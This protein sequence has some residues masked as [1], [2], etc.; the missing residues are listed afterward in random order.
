MNRQPSKLDPHAICTAAAILLAVTMAYGPALRAGFIWDDDAY[1]TEN[2]HLESVDGLRRIWF[3]F[4]ATDQY[5][6]LVFTT[7]WIERHLWGLSPL[8]YHLVNILL[9]ATAS[10]LV[11]RAL[12]K[13]N[14]PGAAFAAAIFALHPVH[15]ESVAW[16]TERKNVLSGVFYLSSLLAYLRF[17][18]APDS[19]PHRRRWY[20]IALAFFACALLSKTVTATLPVIIL[21]LTWWKRGR[22]TPRDV[23]LVVPYFILGAAAGAITVWLE[24]HHVGTEFVHWNLSFADRILIA[25]RAFWFYLAKLVWPANLTFIYSRWRIPGAPA[26]QS[27]APLAAI[28]LIAAAWAARNRIGKGLFV[29][30]AFFALT[31][32]PALGFV[33]VYQ[34]RFSFV[35]DHF[36]YLASLGPLALLAAAA[37][38]RRPVPKR[39]A[40]AG[41]AALLLV[42][43]TLTWRQCEIYHDVET[44]W[45]NT[46]RKNPDSW[47]AH[48]NLAAELARRG[49]I[50]EAIQHYRTGLTL[51]DDAPQVHF[52]LAVLLQGKGERDE[53]MS[54]YERAIRAP[55][56][57]EAHNNLGVCLAESG[58]TDEAIEHYETALNLKPDYADAHGNLANL[59]VQRGRLNEAIEHYRQAVALAPDP[60]IFHYNMAPA[61]IKAGR[62]AEAESHYR[63]ARRGFEAMLRSHPDDARSQVGLAQTRRALQAYDKQ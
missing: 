26:W 57:A 46:I 42:L 19:A 20:A 40:R 61:L 45:R 52:N 24:R 33:D 29:A 12:R 11:W 3:K 32:L 49:R 23:R 5:Y 50:G 22:L 13:L 35:A 43:A 14:V 17:I 58:R 9:H 34:M 51:N 25:G 60:T 1:V 4:G 59:L 62:R 47:M 6:P 48:G 54:H 27:I 56:F 63:E 28:S 21:L 10:I 18:G 55:R 53:A 30:L 36:Q 37:S 41:G 8:G 38:V 31:L 39:L 44:L 7:F 16:I 2:H 15:V